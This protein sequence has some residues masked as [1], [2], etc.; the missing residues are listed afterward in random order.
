MMDKDKFY[1]IMSSDTACDESTLAELTDI[2][3]E[4]PYFS[5][6]ILLRLK[7]LDRSSDQS[8]SKELK[9]YAFQ[10]PDPRK[11]FV[12]VEGK[13][14]GINQEK[15]E[16]EKTDAFALI[17][18]FLMN[19]QGGGEPNIKEDALLAQPTASSDYI[20]WSINSPD[21][22][23]AEESGEPEVRL[24]HQELIDSFIEEDE[25]RQPR[26][27]NYRKD[28]SE[29]VS[30]P[31]DDKSVKPIEDTCFTETL[32]QIYIKQKR[33]EKALQI[34]R[35]LYLKYPEKNVYFADQ[36]RFLE[37]LIINSKK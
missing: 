6:A 8:F 36:I 7:M 21:A 34:I 13:K 17:D 16:E 2:V 11:L 12:I 27:L 32:A 37:K 4:Y 3:K 14:Y 33:Y 9:K 23:S 22:K 15:Q 30:L 18:S 28:T 31:V 19:T 25:N 10:V 24:N 5:A 29:S 26:G 1:E 35:N 20:Y